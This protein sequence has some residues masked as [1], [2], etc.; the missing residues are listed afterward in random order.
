MRLGLVIFILAVSA[1]CVEKGNPRQR[2][3]HAP[4]PEE[5]PQA[6]PAATA[7]ADTLVH[8]EAVTGEKSL[9]L[10]LANELLRP[11]VMHEPG[12][13]NKLEVARKLMRLNEELASAMRGALVT[14]REISEVAK[15][16][17]LKLLEDCSGLRQQCHAIDFF[18]QASNSSSV[19][20]ELALKHKGDLDIYYQ[21]LYMAFEVKGRILDASLNR[22]FAEEAEPYLKSLNSKNTRK[23]KTFAQ[24]LTVSAQQLIASSDKAAA[25]ELVRR[26]GI[27][28]V[29]TRGEL[30]R[31]GVSGDTIVGLIALAGSFSEDAKHQG[32]SAAMEAHFARSDSIR[33][34]QNNLLSQQKSMAAQMQMVPLRE[35]STLVYAIDMAFLGQITTDQAVALVRSVKVERK[36]IFDIL[37]QILTIRFLDTLARTTDEAQKKFFEK[38]VAGDKFLF[39]AWQ[40][41]SD[42]RP[43]WGTFLSRAGELRRL[44]VVL[45]SVSD[46][47]DKM[48]TDLRRV[49]GGLPLNIK[50]I[51]T[52]PT[53]FALGFH[54]SKRDAKVKVQGF[55]GEFEIETDTIIESLF[56]GHYAPW[57]D[58]SEDST[59]LN[60]I[61]L[62]YSFDFALRTGMFERFRIQPDVF[63]TEIVKRLGRK[64]QRRT[65]DYQA[66]LQ[67]RMAGQ[68]FRDFLDLCESVQKGIFKTEMNLTQIQISPILGEAADTIYTTISNRSG[69]NKGSPVKGQA[70]KIISG[71]MIFD[72]RFA[73]QLEES[74]SDMENILRWIEALRTSYQSYLQRVDPAHAEEKLKSLNATIESLQKFR[75]SFLADAGKNFRK[76]DQCYSRLAWAE[77][78][79]KLQLLKMEEA[80]LRQVYKDISRLRA[81]QLT[82]TQIK[83]KYEFRG[84]PSNFKGLDQF[85]NEAYLYNQIDALIRQIS[86]V[87]SGLQTESAKFP[88]VTPG[89]RVNLGNRLDQEIDELRSSREVRIS[90]ADEESFVQEG[91]QAFI[92]P[93]KFVNWFELRSGA[94]SEWDDRVHAAI[95]FN[96]VTDPSLLKEICKTEGACA[97]PTEMVTAKE[98]L[99][100]HSQTLGLIKFEPEFKRYMKILGRN[101]RI[102]GLHLARVLLDYDILT[103]TVTNRWGL[104]DMPANN[105]VAEILG[106][107]YSAV[108]AAKFGGGIDAIMGSIA[109]WEKYR[110]IGYRDLAKKYYQLRKKESRTQFLFPVNEAMDVQMEESVRSVVQREVGRIGSFARET[111]ALSKS[112]SQLPVEKRP[113]ADITNFEVITDPIL[114][115]HIFDNFRRELEKFHSDTAQCYT[116][117]SCPDFGPGN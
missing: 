38:D 99:A 43:H 97:S 21:L 89:V 84:L 35:W 22:M 107:T 54:M 104:Y 27:I 64:A 76:I 20:Q 51:S 6:K 88:A 11:Q 90:F 2:H 8:N 28:K 82:S 81:G 102:D 78:K 96:R 110:H 59:A 106:A 56:M 108:E 16:Y 47:S 91:L 109:K 103:A 24:M 45:L 70:D 48:V 3:G 72:Q 69:G 85:T 67:S 50:Y 63:A 44:G 87:S 37:K 42:V 40:S 92:N 61:E 5:G 73:A 1:G 26:L 18:R 9:I 25:Q 113:R 23:A 39:H 94:I 75:V 95:I 52:Y 111:E 80:H 36:Q 12:S 33:V 117:N 74:R 31:Y 93:P 77:E 68:N 105:V 116:A 57:F 79:G 19:I 14:D 86:Y 32:V 10:K 112:L 66:L 53:M 30:V 101:R 55:F 62:L 115:P 49:V 71:I 7:A 34:A 46:A 29:E 100:I 114:S 98:V 41:A 13:W 4:K 83:N 17:E 60:F 58:Y 15:I 65:R